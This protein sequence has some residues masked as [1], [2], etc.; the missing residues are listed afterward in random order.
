MPLTKE[1]LNAIQKLI[2]PLEQ[3]ISGLEER[4]NERFNTIDENFDALF[5]RD[6]TREQ[7]YLVM[8]E[9]ISHLEERASDL[10]KK[11]A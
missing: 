6:E 4:M 7:E 10:E 2:V 1:D 11:R 5:K 3:R 9:H 8:T